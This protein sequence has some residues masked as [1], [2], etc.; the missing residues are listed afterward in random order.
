[1]QTLI[2]TRRG[3]LV[4]TCI[5]CLHVCAVTVA[6]VKVRYAQRDRR[7]ESRNGQLQ[8]KFSTETM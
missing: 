6:G 4:I 1:M 5:L 2:I 8:V 7:D 3:V